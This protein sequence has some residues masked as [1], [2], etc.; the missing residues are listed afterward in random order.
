MAIFP[1]K[2]HHMVHDLELVTFRSFLQS[3]NGAVV[4]ALVSYRCGPNS[5]PLLSLFLVCCLFSFLLRALLSSFFFP[6]QK[7]TLKKFQFDLQ[8]VNKK[9]YL[10]KF[11]LLSSHSHHYH[12]KWSGVMMGIPLLSSHAKSCLIFQNR[13]CCLVYAKHHRC[14]CMHE[15]KAKFKIK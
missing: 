13:N 7:P 6:P 8:T 11:Q 12:R 4:R 2:K 10:V 9:S 3:G 5:I 15:C 1:F 14:S